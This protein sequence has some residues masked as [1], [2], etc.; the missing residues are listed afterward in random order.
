MEKFIAHVG[1]KLIITVNMNF[2]QVDV[3]EECFF[4][5]SIAGKT[6]EQNI[7]LCLLFRFKNESQTSNKLNI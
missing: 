6:R 2:V 7:L 3:K 1:R 4:S 5:L